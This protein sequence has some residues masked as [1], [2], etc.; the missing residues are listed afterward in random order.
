M[1]LETELQQI[2]IARLT[3]QQALDIL[4]EAGYRITKARA[5]KAKAETPKLNAVGKPYS[6][7]YDPNYKMKHKVSNGLKR[8][9]HIVPEWDYLQ[10]MRAKHG[11]EW[12]PTAEAFVVLNK[13]PEARY[14]R[15]KSEKDGRMWLDLPFMYSP[16][17]EHKQTLETK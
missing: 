1:Q 3:E 12:K 4:K 5:P 11:Q 15:F 6:R 14:T 16:W 13:H 8:A 2:V 17:W 9:S 10:V 7:N